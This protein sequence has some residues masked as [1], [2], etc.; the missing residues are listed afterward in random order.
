MS[1]S[2]DKCDISGCKDDVTIYYYNHGVCA[3]HWR[4]YAEEEPIKLKEALSIKE[5]T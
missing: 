2:N 5:K 1:N 3:K 4:K